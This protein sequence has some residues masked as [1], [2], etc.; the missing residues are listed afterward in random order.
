MWY[1]IEKKKY[2]T[3][4]RVCSPQRLHRRCPVV[5]MLLVRSAPQVCTLELAVAVQR[6]RYARAPEPTDLSS[7]EQDLS[8][9]GQRALN[10]DGSDAWVLISPKGRQRTITAAAAKATAAKVLC[11]SNAEGPSRTPGVLF[12]NSRTQL[13]LAASRCG[14]RRLGA[15]PSMEQH[16]HEPRRVSAGCRQGRF[17][18]RTWVADAKEP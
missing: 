4:A 15:V 17:A 10:V 2:A 18:N 5:P 7:P 11:L 14:E 6:E 12:E 9:A 13:A 16:C 8:T 3:R 1:H